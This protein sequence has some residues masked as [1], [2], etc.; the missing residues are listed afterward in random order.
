MWNWVFPINKN[1]WTSSYVLFTAGMAGVALATLVWLVDLRGRK[2]WVAPF[3]TYGLNP[4]TAFVGSGMMAR[5]MGLIHVSMGG[6]SVSL[7]QA[8]Y[9]GCFASW[10]SPRNASLAYAVA[11]V[12]LWY[13]ILRVI[14]RRG[15]V[16]KV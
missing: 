14:E 15:I 12:V 4:M 1:L 10:L 11:F 9:R 2:R 8:I 3:V 5:T 6:E 7:Q 16:L 13:V